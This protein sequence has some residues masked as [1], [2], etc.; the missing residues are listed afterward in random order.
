MMEISELT[1]SQV[2]NYLANMRTSKYFGMEVSQVR[3]LIGPNK[4]KWYLTELA[5]NGNKISIDQSYN[6]NSNQEA[7]SSEPNEKNDHPALCS[8]VLPDKSIR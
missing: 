2:Y 5:W 7:A 8:L 6:H 3:Q 1:T 4:A